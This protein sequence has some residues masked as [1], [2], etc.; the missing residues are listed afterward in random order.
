VDIQNKINVAYI[1]NLLKSKVPNVRILFQGL[2]FFRGAGAL[3]AGMC[4]SKASAACKADAVYSSMSAEE[5]KL[6]NGAKKAC[7][8]ET[9]QEL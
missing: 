5:G 1:C 6:I 7:S 3:A 8:G 4:T 2:I 9:I